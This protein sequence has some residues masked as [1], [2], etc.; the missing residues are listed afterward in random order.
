MGFLCHLAAR[1]DGCFIN[2]PAG[3][4]LG[5][6]PP[7]PSHLSFIPTESYYGALVFLAPVVLVAIWLFSGSVT[8]LILKLGTGR[9]DFE[10]S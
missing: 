7:T 5:R 9:S 6:I 1:A 10:R 2:L 8:H 4:L 3:I